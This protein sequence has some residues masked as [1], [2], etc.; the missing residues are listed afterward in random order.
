LGHDS[1]YRGLLATLNRAISAATFDFAATLHASRGV[2]VS[3]FDLIS[4]LSGVTAALLPLDQGVGRRPENPALS[5]GLKTLASL[6][7]TG[8]SGAPRWHTPRSALYDEDQARLYPHGNLNCGLAHGIPGPLA[9]LSLASIHDAGLPR[10]QLLPAVRTLVD[11]LIS[12]Q[13]DDAFGPNWPNAVPIRADGTEGDPERPAR[14]AW[15]YGSPGVARALWL[16]GRALDSPEVCDRAV[17]AMKAVYARPLPLRNI[18]SPTFCHGVSG[19]LQVTLRFAAD[20]QDAVFSTAASEL[21]EAVVAAV[22]P[23]RP[24]GIANVE[25][26]GNL[27]DQPGLLDG[28]AG[29]A[30]V[31][32]A[33][34]TAVDPTW[35]RLFALS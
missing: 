23:A 2:P 20:T 12:H 24:M 1:G 14:S 32:L 22:D 16:A 17:E 10:D 15:C 35:D 11:W 33:A 8:K 4:G 5:V 18:E 25:L 26:Q 19:L 3:A 28:A 27:V 7:D 9:V 29:V 6:A 31:L 21:T 34:S 30:L 13:S